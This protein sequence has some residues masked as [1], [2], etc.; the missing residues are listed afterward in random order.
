MSDLEKKLQEK[1]EQLEAKVAGE[2][3]MVKRSLAT[4][5]GRAVGWTVIGFVVL[6]AGVVWDVCVV[7][8]DG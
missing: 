1:K 6:V 3:A 8:D 2:I 7:L 5:M 4:R